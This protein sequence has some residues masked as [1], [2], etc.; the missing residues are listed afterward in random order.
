M[1]TENT[2]GLILIVDD[3]PTNIELMVG[4]LE[5]N[6]EL[7]VATDG[8]SAIDLATKNKPDL[9][10]LDVIK[11]SSWNASGCAAP[12]PATCR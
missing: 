2:K 3:E 5:D 10:L 12:P 9:I 7:L 4:I 1:T 6:Y 8:E 11:P